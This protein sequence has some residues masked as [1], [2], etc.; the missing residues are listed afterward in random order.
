MIVGF[1]LV[2]IAT[3]IEGLVRLEIA[4]GNHPP[5]ALQLLAYFTLTIG[6]LLFSITGLEMGYRYSPKSMKST[7]TSI[8]LLTTAV[9]NLVAVWVNEAIERG[10]AWEILKEG[11]N[12]YWFFLVLLGI[13]ACLYL[14]IVPKMKLKSYVED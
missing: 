4:K 1:V 7:I 9:G 5:V 2:G 6:E 12:F 11:A 10:G 14:L 13:N 8:W 3:A